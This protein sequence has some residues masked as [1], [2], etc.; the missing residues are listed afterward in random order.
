MDEPS[1]YMFADYVRL[2]ADVAII[3]LA[4][5]LMW[6]RSND[7]KFKQ[8]LKAAIKELQDNE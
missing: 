7:K 6:E 8:K 2:A 3:Y 5:T 1:F 4:V